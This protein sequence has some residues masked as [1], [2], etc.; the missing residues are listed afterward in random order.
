MKSSFKL[1]VIFLI[2]PLLIG[3]YFFDN[4]KGYYRFKQYC[5]REG[6]LRVYESL[7]KN[8]GWMADGHWEA[9]AA[10][11]LNHVEFVRYRDKNDKK[12]YDLKYLG[13]DSQRNTSYEIK[14]EDIS[15]VPIYLWAD[16]SRSVHGELRMRNFGY[17]ISRVSDSKIMARYYSFSYSKLDRDKTLLDMPS[18]IYCFRYYE[19]KYEDMYGWRVSLNS[20]FKN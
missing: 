2:I 17:E 16:V 15:K 6:G 19:K 4:I 7:E 12:N 8:V 13:G 1:I 14:P 18:N 9:R 10:S 3:L 5:E 20:A 11:L